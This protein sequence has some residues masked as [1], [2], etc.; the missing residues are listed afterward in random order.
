MSILLAAHV[1]GAALGLFSGLIA[2]CTAKGSKVHRKSGIVFVGTMLV[3][4]VSAIIIAGA[5]SESVNVVAGT[6]TAYLVTTGHSSVSVWRAGHPGEHRR[7]QNAASRYVAES[8]SVGSAR[9]GARGLRFSDS[10]LVDH[11]RDALC[12]S[13]QSHGAVTLVCGPH[14]AGQR[15]DGAGRVDIDTARFDIVVE[16]HL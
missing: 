15:D 7:L 6:F 9:D 8:A 4:C 12:L 16:D 3:M 13:C 11:S 2:L 14:H 1:A 10:Q 5:R